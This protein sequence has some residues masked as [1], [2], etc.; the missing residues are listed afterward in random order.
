MTPTEIIG[1][2]GLLSV[3]VFVVGFVVGYCANPADDHD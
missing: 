2:V 3:S 1:V